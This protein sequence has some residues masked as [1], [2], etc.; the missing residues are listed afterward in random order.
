MAKINGYPG[1][2]ADE[3]WS[4]RDLTGRSMLE[5]QELDGLTICASG[6]LHPY[7]RLPSE[8]R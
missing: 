4:Y 7:V 1:Y 2:D 8:S 6:G 3:R 5:H